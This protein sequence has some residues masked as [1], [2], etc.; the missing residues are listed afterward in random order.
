[1]FCQK[2]VHLHMEQNN[3]IILK[4][5]TGQLSSIQSEHLIIHIDT[6]VT[7]GAYLISSVAP[8][9]NTCVVVIVPRAELCAVGRGRAANERRLAANKSA[10]ECTQPAPNSTIGRINALEV[11][12]WLLGTA[13]VKPHG[14][15]MID[16]RN[17][18][19]DKSQIL[20]R[21]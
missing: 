12:P 1:M 5:V 2:C 9:R 16:L 14:A 7:K 10:R 4:L 3:F 13:K 19:S 18:V 6:D 21:N 11:R 15:V 17:T 8:L 20:S